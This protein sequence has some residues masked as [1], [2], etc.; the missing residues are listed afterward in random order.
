MAAPAP[1]R[2]LW[3]LGFGS[4]GSTD[5]SSN[6]AQRDRDTGGFFIGGDTLFN[7]WRIGCAGRLQPDQFLAIDA[8][9]SS[10][11]SDNVRI[12]GIYAGTN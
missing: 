9:S 4:W 7:D 12:A 10:G 11:S 5:G 3:A 1:A 8:R 2:A 6:A